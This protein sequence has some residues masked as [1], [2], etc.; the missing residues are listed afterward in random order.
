MY[1]S[2]HH[3]NHKIVPVKDALVDIQRDNLGMYGE[4][5]GSINWL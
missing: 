5:A 4:V 1:L 2:N 3:K